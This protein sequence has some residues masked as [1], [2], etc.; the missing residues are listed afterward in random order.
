MANWCDI[1]MYITG[2]TPDDAKKIHE[3]LQESY[4]K[5][6]KEN[7]AMYVGSTSKYLFSSDFDLIDDSVYL[8][9]DVKWSLEYM[10]FSV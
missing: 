4:K 5:A 9:G 2:K 8:H 1:E 3:A 7:V 6:Q 10:S